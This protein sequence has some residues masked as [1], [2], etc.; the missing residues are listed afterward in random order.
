[1]SV[2][3]SWLIDSRRTSGGSSER[4]KIGTE[5][6]RIKPATR[7]RTAILPMS[8][9]ERLICGYFRTRPHDGQKS[10][11]GFAFEVHAGQGSFLGRVRI[12][13][14]QTFSDRVSRSSV[15][16]KM[17][18]EAPRRWKMS[19]AMATPCRYPIQTRMIILSTVKP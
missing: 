7:T 18:S 12:C 19:Q 6:V 5:I 8:C 13:S 11:V 15:A 17:R 3:C 16:R 9:L 1:M 10:L 4:A 2:A 14:F